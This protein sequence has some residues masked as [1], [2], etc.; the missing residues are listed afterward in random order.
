MATPRW[1]S[2]TSTAVTRSI[3][4]IGHPELAAA[5]IAVYHVLVLDVVGAA[6]VGGGDDFEALGKAAG[7][8]GT[9][10]VVELGIDVLAGRSSGLTP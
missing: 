8:G 6:G 10:V 7:A 1:T 2:L 4:Q 3:A 5:E 9:V